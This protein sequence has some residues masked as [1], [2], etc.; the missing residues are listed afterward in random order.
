MRRH[1][2]L[3]LQRRR[4][5]DVHVELRTHYSP[6]VANDASGSNFAGPCDGAWVSQAVVRPGGT[7][8]LIA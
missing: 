7:V 1:S 8:E 6:H 5:A 4:R 2:D 3:E